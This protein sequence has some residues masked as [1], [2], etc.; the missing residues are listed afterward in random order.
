MVTIEEIQA[1]YYMVAAT[2]V[3][4]AAVYYI[5][6]MRATLQTRQAQLFMHLYDRMSQPELSSIINNIRYNLKW[7]DPD[8]F[9]R[10]YGAETN[11]EEYS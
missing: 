9:W 11:L 1:I 10:K 2:G 7:S 8:D 4:V 3:L 5:L 6:N